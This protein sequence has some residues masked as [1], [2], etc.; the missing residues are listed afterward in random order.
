[1]EESAKNSKQT[2]SDLSLEQQ[3]QLWDQAKKA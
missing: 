3:E 2:F 1:M